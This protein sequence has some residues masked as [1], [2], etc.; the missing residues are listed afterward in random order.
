MTSPL[1][2]IQDANRDKTAKSGL[3]VKLGNPIT[4]EVKVSPRV[5]GKRDPSTYGLYW[6]IAINQPSVGG[7]VGAGDLIMVLGSPRVNPERG[8]FV[9]CNWNARVQLY[10]MADYSIDDYLNAGYDIRSII[11]IINVPASTFFRL[12]Y[13]GIPVPQG[14]TF[15]QYQDEIIGYDLS[16]F[17]LEKG[18]A[19]ALDVTSLVPVAGKEAFLLLYD[20]VY[21]G[22]LS[23]IK[24][25][26]R[27]TTLELPT[28]S[29]IES[30][31]DKLP[32]QYAL[33]N[34]VW[35]LYNAQDII[36][37]DDFLGDIR[38]FRN[39]PL[40]SGT[41]YNIS[42]NWLITPDTEVRVE[43]RLT[44]QSGKRLTIANGGRFIV[45]AYD[46]MTRSKTVTTDYSVKA[47]DEWVRADA[48]AGNI[49]IRLLS[50]S[51]A[52][53]RI[54]I[55]AYGASGIIFIEA[56]G[57]ETING[58]N[59]QALK[60]QYDSVTLRPIAGVGYVAT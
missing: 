47:T 9:I 59:T 55:T 24:S 2:V 27:D 28:M 44:I 6:G 60:S 13:D 26:E 35:R 23:Y 10:E 3:R 11:E 56:R 22:E 53:P 41:P 1:S 21:N 30:L 33:P 19:D 16:I 31:L 34:S 40:Y 12:I 58:R 43:N 32:N 51:D 36:S 54:D 46:A 50:V 52:R 5:A 25:V 8:A 7:E 39:S 57:S 14:L 45:E 48:S 20:D 4:G 15:H 49:T 17:Q 42:R 38:Q 29:D 37:A 18:T